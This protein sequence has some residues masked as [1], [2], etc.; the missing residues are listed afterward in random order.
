MD[1][2]QTF[3]GRFD[4][5]TAISEFVTRAAQAAGL[6]TRAVCAV[7]LAVDEA[8]SNIIEHA[9]G[10]A[11]RGDIE[12]TCRTNGD[13]LTVIL[14]DH[15]RPFDPTSVPEPDL[16]ARLEDRKGNGLGF[17]FMRQ[18]M[19]KVHFES[20]LG[21]GNVLTMVKRRESPS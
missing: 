6:D 13:G 10:G 15:G 2:L 12:C 1:T 3:P 7:Q 17:Y 16:R 4:S 5:L 14:R 19:D 20:D 21:S 18:L 11:G 8:C 9:Y